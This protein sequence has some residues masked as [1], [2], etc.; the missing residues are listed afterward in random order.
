MFR[1]TLAFRL[2]THLIAASALILTMGAPA[3]AI[4]FV[5]NNGFAPPNPANVI[6]DGTYG[7]DD[8]YVRN[9]GCPPGWP[10]AAPHAPCAS[11][12]A[13]TT[14]E[15]TSGGTVIDLITN[16]SSTIT[17]T[18]GTVMD[19]LS[20]EDSSTI[21]MT[22]GAA[23]FLKAHDSSTV[24]LSDGAVDYMQANVTATLT[25]TGG[26]VAE[27]MLGSNSSTFAM[28]GGTVWGHLGFNDS[29]NVTLSGGV[30]G[31]YISAN[32]TST[33]MMTG[34]TVGNF[35][36]ANASSTITMS[37]G[38]VGNFLRANN[39]GTLILI[40]SDFMVDGVPVPYGD[41]GPIYTGTLTGTLA[42]GDSL[43]N[44][45]Y[46]FY[47]LGGTIT[48]APIPEPSTALLLAFGLAALAA[49]RRR[50]R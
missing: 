33:I 9:V 34:G 25:M 14:V 7:S 23:Y 30:V 28:S 8:V 43:N 5:I 15:L 16:D 17:M 29:P 48:L 4:S 49:G 35:L 31:D 42:S 36:S 1:R 18:G 3:Q 22:G 2:A 50:V 32:N 37:G 24:T 12:G 11:P 47:Q 6:D 21:T 27:S 10:A 41:L 39:S 40:G 44:L 26:T 46:Q 38:T 13:P 19:D 45:F 20:A